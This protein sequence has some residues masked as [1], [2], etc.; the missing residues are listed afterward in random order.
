M[1]QQLLCWHNSLFFPV[2]IQIQVWLCA[3]KS[4][5]STAIDSTPTSLATWRSVSDLSARCSAILWWGSAGKA[6]KL[7][8]HVDLFVFCS[9]SVLQSMKQARVRL[10]TE[11]W[12]GFQWPL[13][14]DQSRRM[15]CLKL[16][17][18]D[19]LSN[20]TS[21]SY[22]CSRSTNSRRIELWAW[23]VLST[24]CHCST[25]LVSAFCVYL[26]TLHTE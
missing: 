3:Q 22:K 17:F 20:K 8:Y 5:E 13:T 6:K 14:S 25:D 9:S 19:L 15:T 21:L 2:I 10:H 11:L 16:T 23:R 18:V 12:R 26:Q 7:V 24:R 1:N 4:K